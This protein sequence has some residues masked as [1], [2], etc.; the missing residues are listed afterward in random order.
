MYIY[1]YNC[2]CIYIHICAHIKICV[3][4]CVCSC[5]DLRSVP[6]GE[7]FPHTTSGTVDRLCTRADLLKTLRDLLHPGSSFRGAN[8]TKPNKEL[9]SQDLS[10][11][12]V[13]GHLHHYI[14]RALHR[15]CFSHTVSGTVGRLR[16]QAGLRKA[17]ETHNH[18]SDEL[19][20]Q[21]EERRTQA[22]PKS[23][24]SHRRCKGTKLSMRKPPPQ[25]LS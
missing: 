7:S 8:Q 6:G 5:A 13:G 23:E 9:S 2:M 17:F 20:K 4:I 3:C 25:K 18:R 10:E 22:S 11:G 14:L 24:C 1:T 19:I 21:N 16:T 12:V 15:E